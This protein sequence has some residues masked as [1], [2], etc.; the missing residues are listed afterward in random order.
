MRK[1]KFRKGDKLYWYSTIEGKVLSGTVIKVEQ[2]NHG[3]NYVLDCGT[4]GNWE[5]AEEK[6]TKRSNP[7]YVESKSNKILQTM[8]WN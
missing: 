4:N 5:V 2:Y 7:T 8:G 6:L 3:N 1:A